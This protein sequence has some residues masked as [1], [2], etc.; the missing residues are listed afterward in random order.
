MSFASK[1]GTNS[2]HGT[3]YEFLRNDALD[4]NRFFSTIELR[5]L[6]FLVV[7]ELGIQGNAVEHFGAQIFSLHSSRNF[8]STGSALE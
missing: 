8:Q 5:T 7:C 1:S 6:A 3:V 4:A 2:F